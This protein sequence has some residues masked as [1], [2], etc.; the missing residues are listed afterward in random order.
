MPEEINPRD[1]A[2]SRFTD[3][4]FRDPNA[5]PE[6]LEWLRK[7]DEALR[8]FQETGD[9][10]PAVAIGLF[11]PKPLG[12][13]EDAEE[14]AMPEK[15][16]QYEGETLRVVRTSPASATVSLQRGAQELEPFIVGLMEDEASGWVVGREKSGNFH[17]G[18]F[19]SAVDH[20]AA[21]LIE[22]CNAIHQIDEFFS[23]T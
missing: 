8:I 3:N 21:L 1:A 4:P 6:Q 5:T 10:G 9:R 15:L 11:N 16:Y 7:R 22:E 17:E 23:A 14:P 13:Q 2:R 20:A 12:D 18:N 19:W